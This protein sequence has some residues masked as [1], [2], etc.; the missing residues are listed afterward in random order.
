MNIP[1]DT[2]GWMEEG[3]EEEKKVLLSV[4]PS[5]LWDS[6]RAACHSLLGFR[7]MQALCAFIQYVYITI[8][9]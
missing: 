9:L 2:K 4:R 3:E 1:S 7:G 8:T 6:D 5:E